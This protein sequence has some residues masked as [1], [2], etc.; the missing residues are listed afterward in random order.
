MTSMMRNTVALFT[1]T[2]GE[3]YEDRAPR[4]GAA[5]AYY[6]VFA[7]APGLIFIISV[8]ALVLGEEHARS[9]II[10]EVRDLVGS[11]TAQALEAAIESVRRQG[12]GLLPTSLGLVTLMFGLWGVF[13]EL[14]DAL[15]TIWGVTTKPGRGVL[16]IIRERFWSFTMVVGVGFLLLVSLALSAWIAAMGMFVGGTLSVPAALLR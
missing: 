16:V 4:L 13:G 1:E 2:L 10:A 3:W 7:L 11:N 9:Q 5:L 6:M 15:N 8:A 14:Q 12:G